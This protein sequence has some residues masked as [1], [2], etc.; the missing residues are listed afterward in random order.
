MANRLRGGTISLY[1][2]TAIACAQF[3]FSQDLA[4]RAY[5]IS[6]LGSSAVTLGYTYNTGS[7]LIDPAVP[8]ENFRVRFQTQTLSYYRAFNL[9]GRSSNFVLLFPYA[10]AHAN[11]TVVGADQSVY[12]SGIAD[13]RVRFSVNLWGGPAMKTKEFAR[14]QEKG[15]IGFSFTA[16]VPTGQY[17][18][19]RLVN[20]GSNRWAFKPE[21]GV[22]RRWGRWVLEGYSGAW[23]FTPNNAYFPGTTRRTQRPIF[24]LETHLNYYVT[25]RLWVSLDANFWNGAQS[26]K[27]GIE[28]ADR[29]RNSR[30]GGTVAF[31]LNRHQALKFSYSGGTYVTIGGDYRTVSGVWQ[32]SWLGK[33][34]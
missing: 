4:P 20:L 24:A 6:P 21:I 29:Q 19:V 1:A 31:P 14:W 12:R 11:A 16:A 30:A 10:I 26:A 13:G 17:D 28:D 8:I 2:F 27:N 7:V 32:Y 9:F 33:T 18:P 15:L 3:C 22:S 23:F 34:E 5:V 25:R